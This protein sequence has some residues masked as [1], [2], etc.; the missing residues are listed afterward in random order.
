MNENDHAGTDETRN[1]YVPR[2]NASGH[3]MRSMVVGIERQRTPRI[4]Q[5][6][7]NGDEPQTVR[8]D[9]YRPMI[10]NEQVER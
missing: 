6:V 9:R 10:S 3:H 5:N 7:S 1:E 8:K 2:E 4:M